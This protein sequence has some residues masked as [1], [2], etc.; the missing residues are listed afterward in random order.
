M[1]KKKWI[2]SLLIALTLSCLT[3]I[4]NLAEGVPDQKAQASIGLSCAS[5]GLSTFSTLSEQN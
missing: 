1:D 2:T 4:S 3:S 5:G